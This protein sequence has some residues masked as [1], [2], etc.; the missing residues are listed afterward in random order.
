MCIITISRGSY[1]SGKEVAEKVA[2]C[3]HYDCVSR[4]ILLEA[5][6]RYEVDEIKLVKAIHDAPS[7]L[8]RR[9][10]KKETYIAYIR[11]ALV[12]RV[13]S[14][15]VVYHGLA[16]HLL[17]RGIPHVVKVRIIADIDRRSAMEAQREGITLEK[18]RSA[19]IADDEQ[20]RK[21]TQSL[22]GVDPWDSS[23]YDLVVKVDR[24][25]I[26]DAVDIVCDAA[27]R[28]AFKTTPASQQKME[29]LV[30]AC[31]V[32]AAL[33]EEFPEVMV[34]SEYGNVIIHSASGGRHAQKIR[35]AVGALET[36][37]GGINSIE[38]HADGNAPPG[39]V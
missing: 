30:T 19:I 4:D 9:G 7:I 20:R 15:N 33:I 27:K 36:T 34:L 21:W 25:S 39:S 31:A 37:I 22:Y 14:D 12:S 6:D 10:R 1:S 18:A 38:V 5:S 24:L 32:K 11:S 17:L 2:A 28:E 8:E 16:G 26:A 3:L 35:K 13:R 29:D 23:L